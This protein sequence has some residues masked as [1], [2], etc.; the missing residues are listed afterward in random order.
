MLFLLVDHVV[1]QKEN[2]VRNQHAGLSKAWEQALLKKLIPVLCVLVSG[3]AACTQPPRAFVAS[4]PLGAPYSTIQPV[5]LERDQILMRYGGA[6]HHPP[7]Q[8]WLDTVLGRLVASNPDV[9]RALRVSVL[10]HPVPNAFAL[11]QALSGQAG[12]EIFIS[13]GMLALSNDPAE[14][15]AVLA[16]EVAHLT[17][18]HRQHRD[19]VAHTVS[20]QITQTAPVAQGQAFE[21]SETNGKLALARFSRAQEI[22]ADLL[23]VRLMAHAGYD[24]YAAAHLLKTLARDTMQ[25][26]RMLSAFE[27]QKNHFLSSHPAT[28][29]RIVRVLAESHQLQAPP[30]SASERENFIAALQDMVYGDDPAQGLVRGRHFI[31]PTLNIGFSAPDNFILDNSTQALVG[32]LPGK[33]VALRFDRIAKGSYTAQEALQSGWIEKT[34]LGP[35]EPL[36]VDGLEGATAVASGQDWRFRLAAIVKD[37]T[38][39]RFIFATHPEHSDLDGAF[40][41][42][43]AS[44]HVLKQDDN[45]HVR[46]LR[47]KIVQAKTGDTA[48]GLAQNSILPDHA[49]ER[50]HVMNGLERGALQLGRHYKIVSE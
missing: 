42:S 9:P 48:E 41:Q 38:I 8:A 34:S 44:F 46:P 26:G 13:R 22:E 7:S 47:L 37:E 2:G 18:Q 43:I 5:P 30:T 27:D 36:Q 10:N 35:I 33:P 49:L 45:K 11:D 12:G 16:H 39:Y 17:L 24:P 50:F 4:L 40:R 21:R 31:H 1:R 23:G 20:Q 15:A 29:D 32:V 19:V 25:R 3:V 6:Y 14:V 28:P